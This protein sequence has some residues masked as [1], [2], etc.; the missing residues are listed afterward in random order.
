M[1]VEGGS[2][3]VVQ[4]ITYLDANISSQEMGRSPVR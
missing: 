1:Q 4:D 2:V 3:D